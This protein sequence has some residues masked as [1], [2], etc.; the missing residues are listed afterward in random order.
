MDNEEWK[1]E[2]KGEDPEERSFFRV[3]KWIVLVH[4]SF[5]AFVSLLQWR[6]RRAT[7]G[8]I[9]SL[10]LTSAAGSLI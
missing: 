1:L 2:L 6:S 5:S 4:H 3:D 10:Q 8:I 9:D 7:V